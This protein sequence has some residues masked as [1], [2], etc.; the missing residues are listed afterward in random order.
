MAVTMKQ[1]SL[2]VSLFGFL[3]FILGVIAE[4]K[5]VYNISKSSPF[6][7]YLLVFSQKKKIE[8]CWISQVIFVR[9]TLISLRNCIE[10]YVSNSD[11]EQVHL[12]QLHNYI[13]NH[14][15]T[16]FISCLFRMLLVVVC[17]IYCSSC[18]IED[19]RFDFTNIALKQW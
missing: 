13:S 8:C 19:V 5:K 3:S 14:G 9:I 12:L 11:H 6:H 2:I 7:Y 4:N 16:I 17:A 10:P 1:M 15:E 18:L